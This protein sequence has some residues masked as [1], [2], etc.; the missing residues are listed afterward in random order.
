MT[1]KEALAAKVGSKVT[2]NALTV[3]LI[4]AGIDPV[5][6]YSDLMKEDMEKGPLIDLLYQ[7]YTQQDIQEGGFSLSH[8]DF[9][10][11]VRER[12][13]YYAGLYDL[14]DLKRKLN[15]TVTGITPW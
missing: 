6:E 3:A 13:L 10:R 2:D 15:P 4:D 9:L 1:N 14:A 11:K 5:A 8:P 12:L 7:L